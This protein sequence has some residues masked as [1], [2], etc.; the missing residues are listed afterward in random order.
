MRGAKIAAMI[1]TNVTPIRTKTP[2]R[3]ESSRNL[4]SVDSTNTG[5]EVAMGR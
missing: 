5:T 3:F 4:Q 2:V 1:T